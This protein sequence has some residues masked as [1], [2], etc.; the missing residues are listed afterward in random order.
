MFPSW[1]CGS[2][3]HSSMNAA[4]LYDQRN[5]RLWSFCVE[6]RIAIVV[7]GSCLRFDYSLPGLAGLESRASPLAYGRG[8]LQALVKH[9]FVR[10]CG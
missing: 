3:V 9:P 7:D 4:G 8:K 5:P 6:S 2:V 10:S 1:L